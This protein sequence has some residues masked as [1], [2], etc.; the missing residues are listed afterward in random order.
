MDNEKFVSV[1][2]RVEIFRPTTESSLEFFMKVRESN[3][4][5]VPEYVEI[6]Y[7]DWILQSVLVNPPA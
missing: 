2:V 3:V 6:Q 1:T 5:R 7:P 4:D